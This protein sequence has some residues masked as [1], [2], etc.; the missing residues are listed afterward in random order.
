MRGKK[1]HQ[2]WRVIQILALVVAG[3]WLWAWLKHPAARGDLGTWFTGCATFAAVCVALWVSIRDGRDRRAETD[4]QQ[5]GLARSV[6]MLL[7]RAEV[8]PRP[9]VARAYGV[10]DSGTAVRVTV[11]NHG[12]EPILGVSVESLHLSSPIRMGQLRMW[13]E[14]EDVIA[15]V[16]PGGSAELMFRT[17]P[18]PDR[19]QEWR[20]ASAVIVFADGR[21]IR[22]K[23]WAQQPPQRLIDAVPRDMEP[24][25]EFCS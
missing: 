16:P 24:P 10:P 23:R 5:A 20:M 13:P 6:T 17:L 25:Y 1:T 4:D 7:S 15:V 14:G 9:P 21:G 22:W 19:E 12:S 18:V 11:S 8:P 3:G 2:R